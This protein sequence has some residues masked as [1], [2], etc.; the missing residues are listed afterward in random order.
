[1]NFHRASKHRRHFGLT[2]I[3]KN[4]LVDCSPEIST[5]T[6]KSRMHWAERTLWRIAEFFVEAAMHQRQRRLMSLVLP[7]PTGISGRLAVLGI[8]HAFQARER[9]AGRKSLTAK[10]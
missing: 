8:N 2:A 1:M 4:A 9:H 3:A 10:S 7:K 5:M 6:T